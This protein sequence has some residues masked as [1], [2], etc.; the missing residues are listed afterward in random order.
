MKH[1]LDLIK[2]H[3][4]KT[5]RQLADV[6]FPLFKK[7]VPHLALFLTLRPGEFELPSFASVASTQKLF[8]DYI[9]GGHKYDLW[10]RRGP[11]GPNIRAIRHSDHTPL[12]IL[13]RSLFYKNIVAVAGASYGASIMAWRDNSW[14]ATLT[15]FRSFEQGDLTDA[16]MATLRELQPHFESA[17]KRVAG[18]HEAKLGSNSLEVFIWGLPSAAVVLS[19]DL[20]VLH[21]NAAAQDLC[22]LWRFG[23]R[24]RSLKNDARFRV[25][26]DILDSIRDVKAH[27]PDVKPARQNRPKIFPVINLPHRDIAGLSAEVSFLPSKTLA[28][29]RGTFLVTLEHQAE[30]ERKEAS[31]SV[32]SKLS[33]REREIA[34]LA[35]QGLTSPQI[36]KRLGTHQN[37]VRIQLHH[38]Y[39]KLKIH[40]RY[41]L[42]G[43][44]QTASA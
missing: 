16:E 2:L 7:A 21:F 4:A 31:F 37:T 10:L 23:S 13:K 43:L 42:I 33:R 27:I 20:Q 34:K 39:R 19:W 18:L 3:E 36:G 24:A 17:V 30:A 32:L 12:H 5:A 11:I 8:D 25:P 28:L 6:M 29:T 41:E 38:I 26:G 35:L 9:S 44:L 40:S 14:L 15:A 22:R 1:H